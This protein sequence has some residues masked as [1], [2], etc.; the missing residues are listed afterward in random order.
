ML[1]L[2]QLRFDLAEYAFRELE[3]TW[4]HLRVVNQ[5]EDEG[6]NRSL[7][8]P[9]DAKALAVLDQLVVELAEGVSRMLF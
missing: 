3:L 7:E 8:P 1:W 6:T 4:F 5:L 9:A 2:P